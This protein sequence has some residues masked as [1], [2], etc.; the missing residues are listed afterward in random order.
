PDH[1]AAEFDLVEVALL[2]QAKPPH[3]PVARPRAR[4]GRGDRALER[5]PLQRVVTDERQTPN[6]PL[7]LLSGKD[8]CRRQS[9]EQQAGY[10]AQLT[11][12]GNFGYVATLAP[13]C[14]PFRHRQERPVPV[15]SCRLPCK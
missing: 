3:D 1:V 8:G 12:F 15:G 13:Y 4:L 14:Q 2:A 6:Y 10:D 7:L 11:W 5:V 9:G